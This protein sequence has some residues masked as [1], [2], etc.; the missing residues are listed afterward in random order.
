MD[1]FKI[2]K[3]INVLASSTGSLKELQII[4][5]MLHKMERPRTYQIFSA[6]TVFGGDENYAFH[7]G[8]R[9]EIQ[10]NIGVERTED[11]EIFRYGLGFSIE[12]NRNQSDPI[13]YLTPKIFAFNE[14]IGNNI[15]LF[16][17]LSLWHYNN[18]DRHARTQDFPPSEIPLEWIKWKNFIFIGSYFKKKIQDINNED[19]IK[20]V[21]LFDKL[22]PV[23][24]YVE[25]KHVKFKLSSEGDRISRYVGIAMVG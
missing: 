7:D 16:D 5:A 24:E 21:S 10:F 23:Y 9:S 6:A 14:F 12:P 8:G 20:I 15:I 19:L 3:T 25:E 22:M 13:N 18:E 4:R 11:G 2:T 1:I 17:G